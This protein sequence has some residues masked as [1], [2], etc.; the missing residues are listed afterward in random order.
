MMQES[1]HTVVYSD[2]AVYLPEVTETMREEHHRSIGTLIAHLREQQ[3]WS[4]RALAKWVGLDQ[5]AVSRIEAGHRRL[6]ADE[7]QRFADALHVSAD[8]LL[9]GAPETAG[10]SMR[11][12]SPTAATRRALGEEVALRG[13][14][15]PSDSTEEPESSPPLPL[16]PMVMDLDVDLDDHSTSDVRSRALLL[17]DALASA[18]MPL[19]RSVPIRLPRR[20]QPR[21]VQ[22]ASGAPSAQRALPHFVRT[23]GR[24]GGGDARLVRTA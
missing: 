16:A 23:S 9:Q 3:G 18:P 5:S 15:A 17:G 24:S 4:Q 22:V 10:A 1:G 6:S 11:P 2:A 13:F 14:S 21:A 12:P 7:L 19:K 20:D 8:V